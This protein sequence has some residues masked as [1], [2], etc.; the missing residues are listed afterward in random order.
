[1]SREIQYWH[2]RNHKLFRILSNQ[3]IEE[4]C[5]IVRYKQAAKGDIIYFSDDA[6]KRI[7]FLKKGSIKISEVDDKGHDF[8]REILSAGDLFGEL[9]LEGTGRRGEVAQ[10]LS[11]QVDICSFRLS[12]FEHLLERYPDIAL[13]YSKLIGLR[14]HKIRNSYT[15]LVFKDVRTRLSNFIAEWA[16]KEGQW[17][18]DH[19]T[20]DN[21][22]THNDLAGLIC[23]TRQTVT[24]LLNE[25]EQE[26]LIKYNRKEL[27]IPSVS[28]LVKR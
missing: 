6:D 23:A 28:Q 3:Q 21:Y 10:A 19:A 2:L 26:G 14:F 20:I 18:G 1:M 24:Q 8:I 7:Y 13:Q 9:S 25:M 12:D 15:N 11:K 5:I 27:I 16:H 22:L 4:L 17:V